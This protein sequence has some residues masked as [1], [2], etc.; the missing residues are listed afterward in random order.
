MKTRRLFFFALL[1][2]L[3]LPVNSRAASD[4]V[5]FMYHHVATDTPPSTSVTPDTFR[6]HLDYLA[7]ND[8]HVWPLKKIVRYLVNDKPLPEKT[9][10]ITF[11]D[12]YRSVFETAY[13]ELKQRN[14]PFTVFVTTGYIG[15]GYNN[16]MSWKQL[17]EIDSNGG[18]IGNH[19]QTHP[20]LVRHR[21]NE[22]QQ[23]WLQRS[24]EEIDTAQRI[25]A[26]HIAQPLP[27]FAY[28]YGEYSSEIQA[29]LKQQGYYGFGQHSGAIGAYSNPYALPRF[30]VASGYD[31]LENFA[32]KAGSKALPVV[33]A[34]PADG[35]LAAADTTP[36]LQLKLAAAD[37]NPA[38]IRC[39]ASAQ[40]EIQ[41]QWDKA[42]NIL[43]V[44]A[45]RPLQPGRTKFNCTV[46]SLADGRFYWYSFLW[47][48]PET[49]GWYRE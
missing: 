1:L 42:G 48:L 18:D 49:E 33:A 32:I 26:E 5:V 19:S 39:Y 11:D 6:Q 31:D 28:P 4:A 27:F 25:L 13:P 2:S 30:P 47:M 38:A 45:N 34:S 21:E 20:H 17:Q 3:L 15:D 24:I 8:F 40:G 29:L 35:V 16:F 36:V 43:T 23:Q 37:Y 46:P 41:T 22:T 10:A 14:W 7:D 9:V 12:A 44:R